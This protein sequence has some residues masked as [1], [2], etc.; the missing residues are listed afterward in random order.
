MNVIRLSEPYNIN[1]FANQLWKDT[2][3]DSPI[4]LTDSEYTSWINSLPKLISVIQNAGLSNLT[5]AAECELPTG[6]RIDAV[7]LGYSDNVPTALIV[8]MKQWSEDNI[9]IREAG[10]TSIKVNGGERAYQSI[11]PIAQTEGY[12]SYL[13]RNQG[14]VLDG[15][16]KV[17]SCQYLFNFNCSSKD[18][19]FSNDFA[20]Y[21][22][23]RDHMFCAG[24]ETMFGR[25]LNDIFSNEV[26][27]NEGVE[28]AFFSDDYRLT[29]VDLEVFK[30]IAEGTDNIGLI[31]D[32]IPITECI[33]MTVKRAVEG[34]L[35]RK[36]MFLISGAAGTGKTIIGFKILSDYYRMINER[37]GDHNYRCAYTLPRSRT[38]KA[39]LD[40]IGGVQAVFLNNLRGEYDLL[41]VD[42]AHRVTDFNTNGNGVGAA[43]NRAKVVVVLQDDK[44]R[45]LGS[46]IGTYNNYQNFAGTNNFSFQFYPLKLQKRAGFGGYVDRIDKLLYDEQFDILKPGGLEIEVCDDLPTMETLVSRKY[47]ENHS[48]KYYAPYCWKWNS[49]DNPGVMDIMIPA[50]N[51][52]F[53]KQWNPF[54]PEAQYDWYVD[55]VDQVGCIYTAQGLGYDYIA[56]IWWDDLK[57][58]PTSNR[59]EIDFTQEKR[60]DSM[61][62]N[63]ISN[64]GDY[65]YIMKNIYRVLLTRAK[66]GVYIW[67]KDENTKNHFREVVL[68]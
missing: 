40:G 15:R 44:Q 43:L 17:Y 12:M 2:H 5:L 61:L 41:V 57:W 59:W 23:L 16:L 64:S 8:E 11:H 68:G 37:G 56:V 3:P 20:K 49:R 38:I 30:E 39:V 52:V 4:D 34:T 45:V 66:K 35:D 14:S 27:D 13:R 19:L 25:Y 18:I 7:V 58:N 32:Q 54:N 46:E 63:S 26:R 21:N 24:E 42:E 29:D 28:D 55:S 36:C 1:E 67:F 31:E 9:E 6:G 47:N 60:F 22:S 53:Q 50:N 48:I 33:N 62:R 51:P 10:Y 65:D